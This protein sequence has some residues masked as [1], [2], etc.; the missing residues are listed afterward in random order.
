MLSFSR[1]NPFKDRLDFGDINP[2]QVKKCLFPLRG[3]NPFDHF[4]L[5]LS[6]LFF[7][8][9]KLIINKWISNNKKVDKH[10]CQK[11]VQYSMYQNT[12]ASVIFVQVYNAKLLEWWENKCGANDV[13]LLEW[14]WNWDRI[15]TFVDWNNVI[16]LLIFTTTDQYSFNRIKL[17]NYSVKGTKRPLRLSP[18]PARW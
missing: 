8:I 16:F 13:P 12:R 6:V 1:S 7:K 11:C 14:F 9:L 5:F 3:N 4:D 10:D 15:H 17:N 2:Q 18:S